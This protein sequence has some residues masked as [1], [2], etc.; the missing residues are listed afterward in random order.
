VG[1]GL[2]QRGVGQQAGEFVEGRDLG[3]AGAR[4]LLLDAAHDVIRQQP[5]HR[6]DDAVAVG[7]RG[8]LRVDLQR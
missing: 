3:G 2:C 6:A 7:L 5:A 4:E 1:V 8:G